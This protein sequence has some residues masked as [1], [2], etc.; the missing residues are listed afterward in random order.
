MQ[1]YWF[2]ES[3]KLFEQTN[4]L[5]PPAIQLFKK[6][7]EKFCETGWLHVYLQPNG[8]AKYFYTMRRDV[9]QAIADP[10]RRAIIVLIATQSMTPNALAEQFAT[11]RQA[12]SKH[13]RTLTECQ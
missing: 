1:R 9:F 4:R 13:L 5:D 6:M 11:S 3:G 8:F 7:K 12:I 10:T 2:A